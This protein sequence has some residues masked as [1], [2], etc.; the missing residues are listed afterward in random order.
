M[1]PWSTGR[2]SSSGEPGWSAVAVDTEVTA[3]VTAYCPDAAKQPTVPFMKL[4]MNSLDIEALTNLLSEIFEVELNS[5][6]LF[7]HNN[8]KDLQEYCAEEMEVAGQ[9][10]LVE[11]CGRPTLDMMSSRS[12]RMSDSIVAIENPIDS[13]C[14]SLDHLAGLRL[15]TRTEGDPPLLSAASVANVS[16]RL[17][18]PN[19]FVIGTTDP[20]FPRLH[21]LVFHGA[22]LVPLVAALHRTDFFETLGEPVSLKALSENCKLSAGLVAASVRY[23][24]KFGWVDHLAHAK[25]SKYRL[26]SHFPFGA[27]AAGVLDD[28]LA[29]WMAT[30]GSFSATLQEDRFRRLLTKYLGGWAEMRSCLRAREEPLTCLL[31]GAFIVPILLGLKSVASVDLLR[32]LA[33]FEKDPLRLMAV[34][35]VLRKGG[36]IVNKPVLKLTPMGN[37]YWKNTDRFQNTANILQDPISECLGLAAHQVRMDLGL[38]ARQRARDLQDQQGMGALHSRKLRRLHGRAPIYMSIESITA[39]ASFCKA[40]NVLASTEDVCLS[41]SKEV[42]LPEKLMHALFSKLL[43]LRNKHKEGGFV[44]AHYHPCPQEAVAGAVMTSD[45]ASYELAATLSGRWGVSH[46]RYL[47][48][49]ATAGLF[50]KDFAVELV[51]ASLHPRYS[52]VH[53][54]PQGFHLEFVTEEHIEDCMRLEIMHWQGDMSTSRETIARR[55]SNY[56]QGQVA[57]VKNGEMLAVMYSQLIES[58]DVLSVRECMEALHCPTGKHAQ[59]MDIFV[60]TENPQAMMLGGFLRKFV[61]MSTLANPQVQ[62]IVAVT[63]CREY[64]AQGHLGLVDLSFAQ[65]VEDVATGW[66]QDKGLNFHLR[67]GAQ[68]LRLMEGWHPADR[69]NDGYGVLVEYKR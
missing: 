25:V 53:F 38:E 2:V 61:V 58:V 13:V 56:P 50:P 18:I 60:D 39:F 21:H 59:L 23:F 66:L 32:A 30:R 46:H 9:V 62:S 51:P 43:H 63:G 68:F 22:V 17:G 36:I 48:L 26:N 54:T 65:Y 35:A 8:L 29:F 67:D 6:V 7:L 42:L 1:V 64:E 69:A 41:P 3:A 27:A 34:K 10:T 49:A 11:A 14:A 28:L 40:A 12:S 37:I 5:N 57:L 52:L 16:M 4:G 47:L 33:I 15:F 31:D 19:E 55:I 45:A 24:G 44:L 20:R